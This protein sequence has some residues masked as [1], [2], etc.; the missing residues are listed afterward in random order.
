MARAGVRTV[1]ALLGF[2]LVASACGTSPTPAAIDEAASV[3]ERTASAADGATSGAPTDVASSTP[4]GADTPLDFTAR[5]L[6]GGTFDGVE[7]RG[8]DVV[9]WMWAPWCP[10]CNREAPH[11]AEAIERFGDRVTFV[12]VPGHDS[13]DAHEAFVEEHGLGEITHVVDEDG[14]LWGR[15]GITYQPAWVFVDDDGSSQVVAGGL[16]DELDA[17]VQ[18]LVDG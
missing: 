16:Y 6:S 3:A 9:L 10:Q 12:G 11:V 7:H 2:A 17:R 4:P 13:D 18:D 15:F 8:T 5:R 1:V 14:S